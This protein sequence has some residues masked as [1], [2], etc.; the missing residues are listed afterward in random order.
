MFLAHVCNNTKEI[1]AKNS[2]E[3]LTTV[4]DVMCLSPLKYNVCAID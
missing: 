2:V 4:L 1:M 3:S